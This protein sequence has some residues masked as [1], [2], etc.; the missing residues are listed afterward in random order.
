MESPLVSVV[1]YSLPVGEVVLD[2]GL[3]T[4]IEPGN[5]NHHLPVQR[6]SLAV[7]GPKSRIYFRIDQRI[8]DQNP[9]LLS[10][11]RTEVDREYAV[12]LPSS[13]CSQ[14]LT[15]IRIG[16]WLKTECC[17]LQGMRRKAEII[18]QSACQL[19]TGFVL[20]AKWQ[21]VVLIANTDHAV[22]LNPIPLFGREE[23]V[24]RA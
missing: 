12:N 17:I 9:C 3:I 18:L 2:E 16:P 22:L 14:S 19:L 15:G 11:K 6:N 1:R 20:I 23:A 4:G 13:Q 7:T 5:S 8:G 21:E 10:V 24:H